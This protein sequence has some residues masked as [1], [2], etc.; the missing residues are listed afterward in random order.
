MKK[1]RDN[2]MQMLNKNISKEPNRLKMNPDTKTII[3][4]L[5]KGLSLF[6]R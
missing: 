2:G 6:N 3:I 5:I 1:L 4:K